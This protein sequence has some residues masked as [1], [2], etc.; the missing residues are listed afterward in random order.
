MENLNWPG[1]ATLAHL[2]SMV[3]PLPHLVHGM[4]AWIQIIGP[5]YGDR[6]T[7]ALARATDTVFGPFGH[8]PG[9]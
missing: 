5:A 8:P 6:T 7:L 4:P 2:P 1:I 9:F 3:R